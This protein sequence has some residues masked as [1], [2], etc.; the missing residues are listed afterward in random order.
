MLEKLRYLILKNKSQDPAQYPINV[1]NN[2]ETNARIWGF[3]P[4]AIIPEEG[5]LY[6]EKE[7][8]LIWDPDLT[9]PFLNPSE[10]L[11]HFFS[12]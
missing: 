5:S 6:F 3:G 7:I 4:T 1:F 9:S 12:L 8:S 11:S 2:T 10:D